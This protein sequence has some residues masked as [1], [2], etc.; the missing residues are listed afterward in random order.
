MHF[1]LIN[2]DSMDSIYIEPQKALQ[3]QNDYEAEVKKCFGEVLDYYHPDIRLLLDKYP[4]DAPTSKVI[5][6]LNS[7]CGAW[8]FFL[9]I[10]KYELLQVPP[11]DLLSIFEFDIAQLKLT[12]SDCYDSLNNILPSYAEYALRSIYKD[13]NVSDLDRLILALQNHN[14]KGFSAFVDTSSNEW[15]VLSELCSKFWLVDCIINIL[16]KSCYNYRGDFLDKEERSFCYRGTNVL[17]RALGMLRTSNDYPID[18][19]RLK[20]M[21]AS[22]HPAY[23][24]LVHSLVM[25]KKARTG[26]AMDAL[27]T[28]IK[29][30]GL[31]E[32]YDADYEAIS[33]NPDRIFEEQPFIDFKN[34]RA[35]GNE[36]STEDRDETEDDLQGVEKSP[37]ADIKNEQVVANE[38]STDEEDETEDDRQWLKICQHADIKNERRPIGEKESDEAT[39]PAENQNLTSPFVCF[40]KD[41][42]HKRPYTMKYLDGRLKEASLGGVSLLAKTVAEEMR[43]GNINVEGL[44]A[45]K[46]FE[47]LKRRYGLSYGY[48]NFINHLE[49]QGID[50]EEYR[51]GKNKKNNP[52]DT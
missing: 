16:T 14:K 29:C 1:V 17:L 45:T 49:E 30:Q 48:K 13:A 4:K 21:R 51:Q 41:A 11:T 44:F 2:I 10:S 25:L 33:Q 52:K 20:L 28:L 31:K 9:T 39:V 18:G 42:L 8:L 37:L 40:D 50:W 47:M 6:C 32:W 46:F 43:S 19:L 22:L 3:L 5:E 35:V 15:V 24:Y 7:L 23:K 34:E 38:D 12:P 27:L 36:D 26:I